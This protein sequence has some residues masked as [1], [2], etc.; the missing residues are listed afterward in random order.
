[1]KLEKRTEKLNRVRAKNLAPGNMFGK[2][3][4]SVS[5]QADQ[6]E[7]S[8]AIKTYGT[9]MTFKVTLDGTVHNVYIK[10][11][12]SNI[13]KPSTIIHFDLHRVS[14]TETISAQIPIVVVGKEAFFQSRAYPQQTLTSVQAEYTVGHGIQS[15]EVDVSALEV[16]DAI[17]VKDLDVSDKIVLKDDPETLVVAIKE[18]ASVEEP[19]TTETEEDTEVTEET[20]ETA[21]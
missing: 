4:D 12:Q 13:L 1:M 21:E 14:E 18:S 19:E 11:V 16:G 9:N 2:S 8:D 7:L 15:I 20:E 5:V 10:N 17:H 6:K 3:I